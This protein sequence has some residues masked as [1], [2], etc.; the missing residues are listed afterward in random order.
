MTA[1][2]LPLLMLKRLP[3]VLLGRPRSAEG[4]LVGSAQRP[5]EQT[6]A[7]SAGLYHVGQ[8]CLAAALFAFRGEKFV[9]QE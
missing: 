4:A 7:G 9:G 8:L 1:A 6:S 2:A 3:L 5:G